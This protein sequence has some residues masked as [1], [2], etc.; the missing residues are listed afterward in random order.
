MY[1]KNVLYCVKYDDYPHN[2]DFCRAHFPT[3]AIH[4]PYRA[5]L[6][7]SELFPIV[8]PLMFVTKRYRMPYKKYTHF[9]K[10]LNF[11]A[12]QFITLFPTLTMKKKRE[13]YRVFYAFS[14]Q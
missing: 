8:A 7:D 9:I 1:C 11:M 5:A 14:F 3:I 10:M 4:K 2:R 13:T 12:S 6:Y